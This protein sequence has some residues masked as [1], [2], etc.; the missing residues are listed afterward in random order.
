MGKFW[1]D[2]PKSG[3]FNFLEGFKYILVTGPQRAGTTITT[4]MISNDTGYF[5]LNGQEWEPD[6]RPYLEA[7]IE[8][9]VVH[10]PGHCAYVHNYAD[11]DG[12]A[13]VLVRRPIKEIIKSQIRV[14]WGFEQHELMHYPGAEPP[15]AQA[16]Y[17]YWDAHQK[18]I[19]GAK[20]FEI[21]YRSLSRHPMWVPPRQRK[22][23]TITQIEVGRPRGPHVQNP[24][25]HE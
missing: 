16:K 11:I 2:R 19:L 6:F 4:A 9:I 7:R 13:V 25:L 22:N 23:F 5:Y 18:Q 17:D 3:L 20:G 12:L 10:C 15:I 1:Q 21:K 8:P 24:E 14:G